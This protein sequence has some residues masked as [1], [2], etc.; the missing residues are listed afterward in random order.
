MNNIVDIK[1]TPEN[2][3]VEGQLPPLEHCNFTAKHTP[4][5]IMRNSGL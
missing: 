2:K 3:S 5:Y 4:L 1:W